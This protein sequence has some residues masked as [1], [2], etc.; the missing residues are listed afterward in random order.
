[1]NKMQKD[2][3]EHVVTDPEEMN[4]VSSSLMLRPSLTD[5]ISVGS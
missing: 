2:F 4:K 5:V 1:M 3:E